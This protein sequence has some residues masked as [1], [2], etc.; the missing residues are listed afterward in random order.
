M[1]TGIEVI[2]K[3]TPEVIKEVL[4]RMGIADRIGKKI[5]P[6]CYLV[7]KDRKFYICHFKELLRENKCEESDYVRRNTYVWKLQTWNM[8]RAVVPSDI[9]SISKKKLFILTKEQKKTEKWEIHHKYHKFNNEDNK[10][11]KE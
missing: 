2:L 5:Y 9:E 6:S 3:A 4:E 7:E 11:G 8:L 1:T 10:G